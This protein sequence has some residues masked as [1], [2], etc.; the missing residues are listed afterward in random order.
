MKQAAFF[1]VLFACPVFGGDWPQFLGPNRDGTSA[2]TGLAPTWPAKGPPVVWRKSI[3]E[4]FSGPVVAGTRL[5]LFH[6]VKDQEIVEAL[7]TVDGARQWQ[8]AYPTAFDDDFR[9]GDGPRS[10]PVIAGNRVITLG[11]DGAL[12]CLDLE[13]G[14]VLWARMLLKEYRVP[15]SYFGIGTSPVVDD[16]LV[17]VNVGAKDAGIVAFAVADGKEVWKATSDAASYSSPVIRTVAG[18]KRAI[19]FTR[20]GAV[21]LDPRTGAVRYRQRWRARYDA[22][23]NAATPLVIGDLAFFSASYETGALLLKLRPDGADEVWTDD[24]LMSNHYNTCIYHSGY[25]YGFDG[26]QESG[27]AFRCVDLKNRRVMWNRPRFGCGSII[28]ADEKLIVLTER[29][30][31]VLVEPTP[32]EYRELARAHILDDLPCRAQI[33]LA[34][35]KLYAR[36]RGNLMCLNLR[37]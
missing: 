27:A 14:K 36:D 8:T 3:G 37:K 34:D 21:I 32:K 20:E 19:F 16:D 13:S 22:S 25:L 15:P 2:E 5:I 28:L 30:D 33:A 6:R 7:S 4:G 17:L 23:V 29:G 9:K 26:R 18:A 24:K 12:H 11:A 35:G 31:L 10:T 1:F